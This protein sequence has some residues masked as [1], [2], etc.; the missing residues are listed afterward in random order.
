[1]GCMRLALEKDALCAMH[2]ALTSAI[3]VDCKHLFL[4]VQGMTGTS[5]TH[6]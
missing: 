4:L 3:E 6:S 1:M 5:P 2:M